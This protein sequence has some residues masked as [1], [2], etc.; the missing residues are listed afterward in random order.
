MQL[1]AAL[2]EVSPDTPPSRDDVQG[3]LEQLIAEYQSD[4]RGMEIK[5]VAGG[6]KM[7]T[8]AQHHEAVRQF[9]KT[10]KPPVKLSLAALETLAVIAYR[11]PVTVPEIQD[12]RGV[13]AAGVIKTLL[14]KKLIT[15]SGRKEVMGRPILYKTTRDFLVQFGLKDLAELPSLKEFEELSKA[16]LGEPVPEE[17]QSEMAFPA[18]GTEALGTAEE[19][20]PEAASPESTEAREVAEEHAK[21]VPLP[22]TP[23]ETSGE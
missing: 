10:L 20:Q 8:K 11:Q 19:P 9:A 14:D 21:A 7:A 16:A 2:A 5:Q 17:P 15:T 12:V 3:V 4:E 13:H 18:E 22:E 23:P 1:T 6:Y